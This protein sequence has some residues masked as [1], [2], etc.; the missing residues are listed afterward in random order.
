MKTR[1]T[2]SLL[3]VTL[4][5]G[6]QA[7]AMRKSHE[8]TPLN[9]QIVTGVAAVVLALLEATAPGVSTA[10]RERR[11]VTDEQRK[12]QEELYAL[13]H[14][15]QLQRKRDEVRKYVVGERVSFPMGRQDGILFYGTVEELGELV[16]YV[17]GNDG[18]SY[19]CPP[20][21]GIQK[22]SK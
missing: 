16:V 7:V 19:C 17:R 2:L 21:G 15:Q 5:I 14:E 13:P 11:V 3:V 6:S 9:P 12:E 22:E 10:E 18:V 4:L 1:T 20:F 8:S